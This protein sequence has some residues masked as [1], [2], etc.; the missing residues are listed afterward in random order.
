MTSTTVESA[1]SLFS[2]RT[3]GKLANVG[4]SGEPK[5][6]LRSP[7]QSLLQVWPR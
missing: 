4:A 6:Q 7:F 1:I 2:E 5:D 3:K